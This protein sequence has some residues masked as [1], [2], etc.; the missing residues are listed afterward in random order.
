MDRR[1]SVSGI[2]NYVMG[3]RPIDSH[4]TRPVRSLI[5]A[6]LCLWNTNCLLWPPCASGPTIG[7]RV[8]RSS[9]LTEYL[10]RALAMANP[11]RRALVASHLFL[12]SQ[13]DCLSQVGIEF[14]QRESFPLCFSAWNEV[15]VSKAWRGF[16]IGKE[17]CTEGIVTKYRVRLESSKGKN[18]QVWWKGKSEKLWL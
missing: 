5:K 16:W 7:S 9:A 10:Y 13:I 14:I 8:S 12:L 4:W 1:F 6:P 15:R 17:V 18:S 3:G 2:W 11:S